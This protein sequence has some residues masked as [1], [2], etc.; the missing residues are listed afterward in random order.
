MFCVYP[1]LRCVY[2]HAYDLTCGSTVLEK[3][4]YQL[5]SVC[6]KFLEVKLSSFLGAVT[7]GQ[8]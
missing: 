8:N 5:F 6:F 2:F 1:E 4:Q 3:L 7:Y